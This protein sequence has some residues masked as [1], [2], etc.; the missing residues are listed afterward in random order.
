MAKHSKRVTEWLADAHTTLPWNNVGHNG[1]RFRR[2]LI[3][4]L[5]LPFWWA[6]KSRVAIVSVYETVWVRFCMESSTRVHFL[7][8]CSKKRVTVNGFSTGKRKKKKK[9]MRKSIEF[10]SVLWMLLYNLFVMRMSSLNF[11]F[12]S[13]CIS[14]LYIKSDF[15]SIVENFMIKK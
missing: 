10:P 7:D 9:N 12:R 3:R 2:L 4:H 14:I 13:S 5:H 15:F 8:S 11:Y 6:A 1:W